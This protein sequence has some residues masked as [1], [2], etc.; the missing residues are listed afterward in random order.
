[1]N[2]LWLIMIVQIC[3]ESLPISSSSHLRLLEMLIPS[4]AHLLAA[5]PEDFDY[6]LHG[7]TVFIIMLF[8]F[9]AWYR[10]LRFLAMGL[11]QTWRHKQPMRDSLKKLVSI[12]Y[13]QCLLVGVACVLTIMMQ[14]CV[15]KPF[16]K[17]CVW[18]TS[19]VTMLVGLVVTML[20]LLSLCVYERRCHPEL[21]SSLRLRCYGRQAGSNYFS[22]SL[23]L[24]L[25][26]A[27]AVLPG[28]SR[29]GSTFVVARWLG[30]TPRRAFQ[31]SLLMQ[32]P[33]IVAAFF[34][35]GLGKGMYQALQGY[36]WLVMALAT[37]VAYALLKV[38]YTAALQKRFWWFGVYMIVPI[39]LVITLLI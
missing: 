38:A 35:H 17:S 24:G 21:D 10:P 26:Q 5:L 4:V 27:F 7:P 36:D 3:V 14:Y 28:I 18:Y 31:T 2:A 37:L 13:R 39:V 6:L 25:T 9:Q 20:M 8:F 30:F 16:L 11:W 29:L 23:I 15:I 22:I 33:L 1:M 19:E 34:V 32:F 12:F